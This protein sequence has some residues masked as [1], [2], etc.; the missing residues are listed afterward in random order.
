[1]YRAVAL[2]AIRSGVSLTDPKALAAL[3]KRS[4]IDLRIDRKGKL[5]VFLDGADVTRAIR[6]PAVSEAASR[7]ATKAAL[8]RQLV[9]K[10]Q[11]FGRRGGV[12]AEGR[13]TGTVVFPKA[14]LKIYL[15]ASL[16]ERARRRVSQLKGQRHRVSFAQIL[17][18]QRLRDRR[19]RG[20]V[21]SPLRM[22]QGAVRIDNTGL[23]SAQVLDKIVDYVRNVH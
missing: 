2:K 15:T 5:Q 4:G 18:Q 9:A 17:K 8:R 23:Q 16:K 10:Q 13:D 14:D 3:A 7:I 19:D 1:M 12:V 20:R 6:R 22:A 21:A 11:A